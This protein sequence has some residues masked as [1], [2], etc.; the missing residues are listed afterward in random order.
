MTYR[1]PEL[2]YRRSLTDM[3]A[4]AVFLHIVVKSSM[5]Y[6]SHQDELSGRVQM[7]S[8]SL[9]WGILSPGLGSGGYED[10]DEQKVQPQCAML[11]VSG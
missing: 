11:C 9:W 10:M 2:G 1:L 5:T 7:V 6:F 3:K 8:L 4:E